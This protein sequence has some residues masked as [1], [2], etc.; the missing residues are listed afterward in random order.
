MGKTIAVT[1]D[2]RTVSYLGTEYFGIPGYWYTVPD[3]GDVTNTSKTNALDYLYYRSLA[4]EAYA[5]RKLGEGK[6]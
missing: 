4:K 2:F 5:L 6:M 1:D 3:L